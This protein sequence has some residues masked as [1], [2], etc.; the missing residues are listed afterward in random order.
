VRD[1][2]AGG[3]FGS[4][5]GGL[6]IESGCLATGIDWMVEEDWQPAANSRQADSRQENPGIAAEA[7]MGIISSSFSRRNHV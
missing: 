2:L 4:V 6:T 3:R 5:F 7:L 1:G